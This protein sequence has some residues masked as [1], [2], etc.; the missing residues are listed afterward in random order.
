MYLNPKVCSCY[1]IFFQIIQFIFIFKNGINYKDINYI[2]QINENLYYFIK[3]EITDQQD[4]KH[5]MTNYYLYFLIDSNVE[6]GIKTKFID[7]LTTEGITSF[8]RLDIIEYYFSE[9]KE[10]NMEITTKLADA[11]EKIT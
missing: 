10:L 3:N 9:L 5:A 4:Y 8:D 11:L 1:T 7:I 6:I 2:N